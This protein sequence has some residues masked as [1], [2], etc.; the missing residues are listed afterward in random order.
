MVFVCI[1][2]SWFLLPGLKKPDVLEIACFK[3][4]IQSPV[5]F[6]GNHKNYEDDDIVPDAMQ[7]ITMFPGAYRNFSIKATCLKWFDKVFF[8]KSQCQPALMTNI[9]PVRSTVCS[10]DGSPFT[11]TLRKVLLVKRLQTFWPEEGSIIPCFHSSC[12]GKK[13]KKKKGTCWK[14]EGEAQRLYNAPAV[15][16][17]NRLG[18]VGKVLFLEFCTKPEI[19][20]LCPDSLL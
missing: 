9:F 8:W 4:T 7:C 3:W 15:S 14:G 12:F 19:G 17:V 16:L 13:Q 18:I 6:T 11:A 1:N 20:W 10:L 2:N 5:F